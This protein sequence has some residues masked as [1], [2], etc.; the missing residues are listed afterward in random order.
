M[1]SSVEEPASKRAK[2]NRPQLHYGSGLYECIFVNEVP[3][4]L[5]LEC[6]ICLCVL[7][8]PQLV[9][10]SCGTHFC[11]SCLAPIKADKKPCPLCNGSFS[12]TLLDRSLQRTINNLEVCCSFKESGCTWTGELNNLS[13]H[14]NVDESSKDYSKERGCLYAILKCSHCKDKFRREVL[15]QHETRE[16]LKRPS[17]CVICGEFKSTFEEV[18]NSHMPVCP[19]QLVTCPKQCGTL[20][21]AKTIDKHLNGECPLQLTECVCSYAGCAVKLLRKDMADHVSQNLAHHLSLMTVSHKQQLDKQA[22]MQKEI[23]DLKERLDEKT[24]ALF[25][26][27]DEAKEDIS[28]LKVTQENLHTHMNIL[29]IHIVLNN[30]VS[31]RKAGEIWESQPFYSRPH[32]YKMCLKVY[33]NG[34][35]EAKNTHISVYVKILHGDFDYKHF[36]PFRGSVFVII[37]DHT[38]DEEHFTKEIKF[39]GEI[40]PGSNPEVRK[41][42]KNTEWGLDEFIS[43]E[44]L[45][46]SFYDLQ[47]DSVYFEISLMKRDHSCNVM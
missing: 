37:M 14:L 27:V 22:A 33:T 32:G 44:S 23:S 26:E 4:H 41:G 1:D 16:C 25:C 7:Q 10:C 19:S 13:D 42:D 36:W 9:D 39:D 21:A 17:C 15:F 20:L 35:G 45:N 28:E 43:I 18:T 5:Q 3:D 11:R 47:N 2:K 29:P 8:E 31:K 34:R 38:D 12:T 40:I 6:P 24:S 46:S 30:F